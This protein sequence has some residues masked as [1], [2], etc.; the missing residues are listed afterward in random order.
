MVKKIKEKPIVEKKKFRQRYVHFERVARRKA[1]G[2]VIADGLRDAVAK[3]IA[4]NGGDLVLME[5]EI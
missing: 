5:K 3:K 1:E 4:K 2:W